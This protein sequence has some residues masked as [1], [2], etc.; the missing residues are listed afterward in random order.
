[1]LS[2]AT[3]ADIVRRYKAMKFGT[4]DEVRTSFEDFPKKVCDYAVSLT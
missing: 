2:A 3:L 1:L 4:R